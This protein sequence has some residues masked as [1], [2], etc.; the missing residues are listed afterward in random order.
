MKLQHNGFRTI[1]LRTGLAVAFAVAAGLSAMRVTLYY[2]DTFGFWLHD[3]GC[4]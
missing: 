2:R 4:P 1:S 3:S